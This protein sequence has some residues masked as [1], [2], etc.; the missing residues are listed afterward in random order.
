MIHPAIP[1]T[2]DAAAELSGCWPAD[3]PFPLTPDECMA[4]VMG[5]TVKPTAGI[6]NDEIDQLPLGYHPGSSNGSVV[7]WRPY[8]P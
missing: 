6:T 3:K 4:L 5:Y 2:V 1:P 7:L 8:R